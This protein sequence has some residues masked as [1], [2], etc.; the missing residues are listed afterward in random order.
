M[1][2]SIGARYVARNTNSSKRL[3]LNTLEAEDATIGT[4]HVGALTADSHELEHDHGALSGLVDDDHVQYYNEARLETKVAGGDALQFQALGVESDVQFD[5]VTVMGNLHVL[6]AEVKHDVDHYRVA[7]NKITLNYGETAAGVLAGTAGVE[8]DR[9]TARG[10]EFVFDED[11]DTF[12]VGLAAT[13]VL[14]SETQAVA[15]R[16]DVPIDNAVVTWNS[17]GL[18]LATDDGLT[19]DGATLALTSNT[20]PQFT[21]SRTNVAHNV[22]LAV[23]GVGE[24]QITPAS[25]SMLLWCANGLQL[26]HSSGS[27]NIST[28]SPLSGGGLNVSGD[29]TTPGQLNSATLASGSG[30]FTAQLDALNV[31]VGTTLAAAGKITSNAGWIAGSFGD[32]ATGNRVVMGT[33]AG[34]AVIGGHSS[35]EAYWRPLIIQPVG[36]GVGGGVSLGHSA[37]AAYMLDLSAS[38]TFRCGAA[39]T[40]SLTA[41]A[42]VSASTVSATGAVTASTV[43]TSGLVTATGGVTTT[44]VN[45]ATVS[46]TSTLR[47]QNIY[48]VDH[49]AVSAFYEKGT[50]TAEIGQGLFPWPRPEVTLTWQ[51]VGHIVTVHCPSFVGTT[52][53][54]GGTAALAIYLPVGDI[55]PNPTKTPI[56][57]LTTFQ[58]ATSYAG[59]LYFGSSGGTID[60]VVYKTRWGGGFNLDGSQCG[61]I[62]DRMFT[63]YV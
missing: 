44:A 14:P 17:T 24:L 12:R 26:Q 5:D 50:T 8:I 39:T 61:F 20:T 33:L 40:A 63:Y 62:G 2:F 57:E 25:E 9:G 47:G 15:T 59:Y 31:V 48:I 11:T 13:D 46:A 41:T 55:M 10:Y 36:I 27:G 42:S 38:N 53:S 58:G 1:A 7:D 43:T 22:E 60:M 3:K 37:P 4:L 6:G 45:C 19:W 51:R 16:E 28:L 30:L 21:L 52:L 18:Q 54:T 34:S 35:A 29:L 56:H 32:T 23:F 49:D